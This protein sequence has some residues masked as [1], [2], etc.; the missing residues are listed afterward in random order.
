MDPQWKHMV[1]IYS[2]FEFLSFLISCIPKQCHHNSLLPTV[3]AAWRS[4][5]LIHVRDHLRALFAALGKAEI[6]MSAENDHE[7]IVG[8][9]QIRTT[10]NLA[11]W[12]YTSLEG[13]LGLRNGS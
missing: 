7:A 8:R 6:S 9:L 13:V 12:Y 1:S 4:D 5:I 3:E 10:P 2:S 11:C